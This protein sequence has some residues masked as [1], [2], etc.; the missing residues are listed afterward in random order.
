M[1]TSFLPK[2]LVLLL[3]C[4]IPLLWSQESSQPTNDKTTSTEPV[5]PIITDETLPKGARLYV[6]PI[7]NGFETYITAGIE[8]KK[9]PSL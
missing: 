6:A 4:P 8:K 7:S 2:V 5:A 9:F 1:S 3:L